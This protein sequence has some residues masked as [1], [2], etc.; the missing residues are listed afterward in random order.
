MRQV[1]SGTS[2]QEHIIDEVRVELN[3][4]RYPC[5]PDEPWPAVTYTII[6]ARAGVF[7]LTL[8]VIPG[9]V[10]TLCARSH[11][12]HQTARNPSPEFSTS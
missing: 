4:Y 1:T 11:H 12:T 5:C 10:V 6:L 9:I 2:Y 8:I 3:T 7:Y